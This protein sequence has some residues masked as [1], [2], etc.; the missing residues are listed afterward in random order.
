MTVHDISRSTSVTG[1]TLSQHTE[2]SPAVTV[3]DI[4]CSTSV[5]GQ[6]RSQQREETTLRG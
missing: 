1:Q 2:V 4:S 3:H 6:T 5:T